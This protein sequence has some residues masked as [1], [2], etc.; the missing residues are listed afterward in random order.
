MRLNKHPSDQRLSSPHDIDI[1]V[2]Q[3]DEEN[4]DNGLLGVTTM[5]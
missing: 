1:F 3:T 4:M 2:K 5:I